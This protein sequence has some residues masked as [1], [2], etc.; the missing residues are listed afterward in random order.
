MNRMKP[1]EIK[2]FLDDNK[3]KKVL[4]IK[5]VI[6]VVEDG[7]R[8]KGLGFVSL[9]P[10]AGPKL[11]VKGAFADAMSVSVFEGGVPGLRLQTYG[12]KWLSSFSENLKKNLPVLN[13]IIILND[14]ETGFP[15]AILKGNHIT[16]IRTAG[17]SAVCAKYLV[18]VR[19]HRTPVIGIFGLGL[20]AYIHVLAFKTIFKNPRFFLF[21]HGDNFLKD[22][23]KKFP[24]E[25]FL[26][27]K[28]HHEVVQNSD[29][30]L[31]ATTFPSKITPYIFARDLKDDVLILP[32]DYGTRVDPGIYRHLD[33]IYTDDIPQYYLKSKLRNYFPKNRPEIKKEVGDLVAKNYKRP[34]EP[35][36]ILVFNLGIALFDILCAQLFLKKMS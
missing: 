4:K 23:I 6:K 31:S 15:L 11:P 13:S 19:H 25:K 2:I 5:D 14:P 32:L 10:K 7:F 1:P 26:V 35:K 12:I 34:K 29:I 21:N 9:P 16:A 30:I 3:I 22:F 20:Q 18:G 17:V 28:N 24:K 8:K 36:R 33:A 27:S